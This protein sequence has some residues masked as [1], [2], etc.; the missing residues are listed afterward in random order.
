[1]DVEKHNGKWFVKDHSGLTVGVFESKPEAEAM[2]RGYLMGML[3]ADAEINN[4]QI[5]ETPHLIM[6]TMDG[7]TIWEFTASG[8]WREH[9]IQ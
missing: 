6:P 3:E 7:K 2:A 9:T 8:G 4:A 5:A 1:M